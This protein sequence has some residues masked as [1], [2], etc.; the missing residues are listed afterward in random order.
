MHDMIDVERSIAQPPTLLMYLYSVDGSILESSTIVWNFALSAR[1]SINAT[2]PNVMKFADSFV[3]LI[4]DGILSLA[5]SIFNCAVIVSDLVEMIVIA[6]VII[7]MM[8][9]YASM[10][11]CLVL[12]AALM[13]SV[14][15]SL[16]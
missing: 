15:L 10:H 1:Q 4:F 11:A 9:S 12:K 7:S 14:A 16:V 3:G 5:Y 2:L 8:K 13:D 6:L